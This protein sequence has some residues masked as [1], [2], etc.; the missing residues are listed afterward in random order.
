M[1]VDVFNHFMPPAYFAR[2]GDLIPGHVVLSAFP[3]LKTLLDV[4]ARLRLLDQFDGLQQVL[5]LAN[6]PIELIATPDQTPELARL[7]NDGLA[8]ICRAH[9][10]RFCRTHSTSVL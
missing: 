8:D 9:P 4:D 7:A 6:P 3:R 2:L 10:D 1:I 5:S